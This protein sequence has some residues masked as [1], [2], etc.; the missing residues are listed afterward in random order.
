MSR[1]VLGAQL[2]TVCEYTQ[3]LEDLDNTLAKISDIGYKAIQISALGPIEPTAVRE[4][5]D[6][7]SLVIGATHMAWDRFLNDLDAVI[8]EHKIWGC[9]NAAIGSLPREYRNGE[10]VQRFIDE[11]V[12]VS[13]RLGREGMTFSYHNHEREFLRYGGKTWMELL[14]EGTDAD[15]LNFELDTYWVQFGGAD[16]IAWLEKCAGRMPVIHYK[17][18]MVTG[19]RSQRFAAIGEGNLNWAGIVKATVAGGVDFVF[20]EQDDCYGDDPFECLATSYNNLKAMG[21]E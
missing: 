21:L 20:I 11:L 2:Y 4:L 6:K 5:A 12:P 10:G 9:K 3:T 16:P 13:K 18:M 14:F 7:Y 1:P 8:E 15:V 19:D 17:D